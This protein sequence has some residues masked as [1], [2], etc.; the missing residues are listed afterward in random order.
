[1]NNQHFLSLL[2]IPGEQLRALLHHAI[3]VK[4]NLKAGIHHSP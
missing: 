2:D 1:M 4:K 3:D